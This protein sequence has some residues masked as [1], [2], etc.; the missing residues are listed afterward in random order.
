MNFVSVHSAV[1][2]QWSFLVIHKIGNVGS[3]VLLIFE[4]KSVRRVNPFNV[5]HG[6]TRM[7]ISEQ[8]NYQ[9][10]PDHL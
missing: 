1:E 7:T 9:S 5:Y 10:K 6:K 4:N 2:Q 8:N 3:F